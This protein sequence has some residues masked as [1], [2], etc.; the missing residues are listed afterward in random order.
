MKPDGPDILSPTSNWPKGLILTD[1]SSM[2]HG[3]TTAA[4]HSEADLEESN[5]I[6]GHNS[7]VVV[8]PDG[9]NLPKQAGRIARGRPP[10]RAGSIRYFDR[11]PTVSCELGS[12]LR[13]EILPAPRSIPW[14]GQNM[15][16]R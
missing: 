9:R 1:F 15:A 12:P 2:A 6:R 14:P 13:R 5:G 16:A 3:R 7:A 10:L 8:G 4:Q 11:Y